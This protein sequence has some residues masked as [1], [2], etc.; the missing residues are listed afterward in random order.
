M[1]ASP[2]DP[3]NSHRIKQKGAERR[4]FTGTSMQPAVLAAIGT[5]IYWISLVLKLRHLLG[6]VD[7]QLAI[8]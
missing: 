8:G 3:R 6:K 5:N 7:E 4:L 2:S 1:K